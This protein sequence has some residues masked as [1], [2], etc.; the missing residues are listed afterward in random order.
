MSDINGAP[1]TG[2]LKN[3]LITL[4]K[5]TPLDARDS[6]QLFRVVSCHCNWFCTL[7]LLLHF[8]TRAY[9][10]SPEEGS[11]YVFSTQNICCEFLAS[12]AVTFQ[13]AIKPFFKTPV[14]GASLTSWYVNSCSIWFKLKIKFVIKGWI[15]FILW[16]ID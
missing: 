11:C 9:L 4:W 13:S 12:D 5:I 2:V 16:I 15:I 1:K 10:I 14:F 6:Q 8:G 3:G 7:L